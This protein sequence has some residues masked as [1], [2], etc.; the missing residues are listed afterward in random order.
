MQWGKAGRGGHP[1]LVGVENRGEILDVS[2]AVAA[3]SQARAGEAQSIVL[4]I[5]PHLNILQIAFHDSLS[6]SLGT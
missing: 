3:Q 6:H 2:Q 5:T 1:T 4:P